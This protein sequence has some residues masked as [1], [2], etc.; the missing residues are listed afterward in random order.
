MV[1]GKA[2][3]SGAGQDWGVLGDRRD[4]FDRT[5]PSLSDEFLA[6][7]QQMEQKNPAVEA[8]KMLLNG[9]IGARTRTNVVKHEEFSE[10]LRD[11]ITRSHNRSVDAL[12]VIQEL[13]ALAKSLPDHP[14]TA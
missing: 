1:E 7:L 14:T 12:Q 4:V 9:E 3:P 13:I 6:E 8:L 10:R 2:R 5:S 11:A